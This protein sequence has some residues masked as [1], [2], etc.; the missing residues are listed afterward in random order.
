MLDLNIFVSHSRH[1][2]VTEDNNHPALNFNIKIQDTH[3]VFKT[4]I[5]NKVYNFRK[6]DFVSLHQVLPETNWDSLMLAKMQKDFLKISTNF[7]IIIL[8]NMF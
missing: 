3:G 8:I 4:N 5:N 2:S 7:Y 1:P 6:P